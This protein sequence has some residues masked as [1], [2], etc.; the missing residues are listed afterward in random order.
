L[1]TIRVLLSRLCLLSRFSSS[2]PGTLLVSP[3][4]SL[5]LAPP[6][7]VHQELTHRPRSWRQ[8]PIPLAGR[9]LLCLRPLQHHH[10]NNP[11]PYR[12]SS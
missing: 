7:L 4:P 5:Y 12:Q 9:S 8:L 10:L 1:R 2:M 3:N 11:N 6:L